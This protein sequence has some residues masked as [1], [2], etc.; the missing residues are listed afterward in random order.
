MSV[1]HPPTLTIDLSDGSKVTLKPW[2][3]A[4]RAQ[5]RPALS[6]LL[7]HLSLLE[8]GLAAI[9]Q[10]GLIELFLTAEEQVVD[11]C[12]AT[13]ANQINDE[14]WDELAWEDLPVIAQA[15]WEL[16]VVRPDGGG[17]LGKMAA[18][19]GRVTAGAM[20]AGAR[21]QKP[22][23]G[24]DSNPPNLTS[25]PM[26]PSKTTSKPTDSPSSVDGGMATPN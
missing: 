4:Q 5:I 3:M 25:I 26:E 22:S 20:A 8:G 6:Q 17:L 7:G 16:N 19:L 24:A 14:Q 1:A 10:Q 9:G 21:Q 11:L 12:R 23:N 2:T 18:G 15:I 13:V